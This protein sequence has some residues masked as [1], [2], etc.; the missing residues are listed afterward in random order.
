LD[1]SHGR[2]VLRLA[3]TSV[4]AEYAAPGLLELFKTR[5][6]DL[7]VELSVHGGRHFTDLLTSRRADVAIG[8]ATGSPI[9]GFRSRDFLKYQLI[10]VVGAQHPLAQGRVGPNEVRS[11]HWLLG[12]SALEEGGG[13][14]RLLGHFSVPEANQ[15]IFQSHGAA[16]G[17]VQAGGGI[18]VFPEFRAQEMLSSGGLRRLAVPGS[19]APGTW[20]ATTLMP[21][22]VMPVAAELVRF[23][24]TPRAI[25][26]MLSGSGTNISRF[27]P[28][29]HVT[30][31][32]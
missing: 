28:S 10:L 4:F 16:I 18:G 9:E 26:A 19:A 7:E 21:S 2:R 11:A 5:A 25:Q 17:E 20:A 30:L 3:T 31:W 13:T 1:A 27:R 15:R 24:T 12:P 6:D 32:N 29:V 14:A 22:Q 23:I 8:P